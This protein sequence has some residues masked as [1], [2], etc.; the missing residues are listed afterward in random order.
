MKHLSA[1][2]LY[3]LLLPDRHRPKRP[4]SSRTSKV[5]RRRSQL[6]TTDE[7]SIHRGSKHSWLIN[8]VY[9]PAATGD[10]ICLGFPLPYTI[11][12][13][14]AQPGG[15]TNAN[16]KYMHTASVEGITDGI[17]CCSFA[18]PDPFAC[19]TTGNYFTRMSSDV[20]TLGNPTST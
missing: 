14:P 7:G 4:S 10:L 2:S 3:R 16:G 6:N 17:S 1:L 15:I 5:P 11:V 13:T 12:S 20:S 19:I 9:K 18:A 8:N